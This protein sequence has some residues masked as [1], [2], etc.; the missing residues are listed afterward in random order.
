MGAFLQLRFLTP[1][2]ICFAEGSLRVDASVS[3]RKPGDPLGTRAEVKNLNSIN[4]V[5]RAIGQLCF[6]LLAFV[7]LYFDLFLTCNIKH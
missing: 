3:L 1:T 7:H 5:A 6:Y 2:N 4:S